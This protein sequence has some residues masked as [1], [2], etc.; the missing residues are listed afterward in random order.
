MVLFRATQRL[1]GGR[2]RAKRPPLPKICYTYSTTMKR[3]SHTSSKEHPKNVWNTPDKF[4]WHQYFY[5]RNEQFLLYW[6]IQTEIV[7]WYI[8]SNSS[9][10][11]WVCIGCLQ[12]QFWW[13]QQN[14][15]LQVSLKQSVFRRN[16]CPWHHQQ[17]FIAW[18]NLYCRCGRVAKFDNSSIST[19]DVTITLFL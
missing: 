6:K 8:L 5:T 16:F 1:G 10:Y 4:C 19:R 11:Y 12:L 17:H 3:G 14:G 15:L 9:D 7:F 2:G 18:I 13:C